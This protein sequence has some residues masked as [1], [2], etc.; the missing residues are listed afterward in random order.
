MCI[1][2]TRAATHSRMT[3]VKVREMNDIYASSMSLPRM[4][5]LDS[6]SKESTCMLMLCYTSYSWV[7][8]I[9]VLN[10]QKY[11]YKKSDNKS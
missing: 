5:L 7:G 6:Y 3:A 11:A 10:L 2:T 4:N 8:D 9:V 1:Y